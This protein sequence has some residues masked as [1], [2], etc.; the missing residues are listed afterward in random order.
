M[1][2]RALGDPASRCVRVAECG[3]AIESSPDEAIEMRTRR[4]TDA[5]PMIVGPPSEERIQRINEWGRGAPAAWRQSVLILAL[6]ACTLALLGVIWRLAGL[7]L[8]RTWLRTVC[9]KKSKPCA[10]GVIIV[11]WEESRTPRAAQK[12]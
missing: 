5:V 2:K 8:G 7:P 3:P 6:M 10:S 4:T 9:P 11:L 12:A 1:G